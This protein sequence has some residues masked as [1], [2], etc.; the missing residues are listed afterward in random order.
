MQA[1]EPDDLNTLHKC[2]IAMVELMEGQRKKSDEFITKH[3][4]DETINGLTEHFDKRFDGI[5]GRLD[6]IADHLGIKRPD[7]PK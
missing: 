4:L 3:Y 5:D 1:A 6:A 7:A 2:M